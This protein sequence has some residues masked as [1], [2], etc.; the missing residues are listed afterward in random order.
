MSRP[1]P[2]RLRVRHL[3]KG[4]GPGGAERLVVA[5]VTAGGPVHHDVTFLVPEKQH[6]VPLLDAAGVAHRCLDA[7][8]AA[9]PGWIASLRS[10]LTGDPVD[11]LHVHSPALAAVARVLVRTIPSSRRPKVV[12]TEHNR[13]PRH[14]RL[15]RF[16]NRATIRFQDATI[17]VSD[18]VKATIQGIDPSRVE[19]IVHGIDLDATRESADR[20]SVRRELGFD[21]TD[22]VVVCVANL[23]KEKSLDVLVDAAAIALEREPRLRYVLVGQGPLARDVD[24]WI[25]HAGIGDRFTALGY[26]DDATRVLS[27]GDLFTLSSAHEGL[28]VAVMEA[29]ALGL[30]VVATAAG[31]VPAAVGGA[32]IVAAV[33]DAAALAAGHLALATDAA[34]RAELARRATVESERFALRRS[35]AEIEAV[36]AGAMAGE[37]VR[38]SSHS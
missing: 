26:R 38:A 28:P 9:R 31:G 15:T 34:R 1:D 18:D 35:I 19:V 21:A 16:A 2:T 3:L 13:W 14:H 30:P 20:E 17:A 6:L 32:G 4:L 12:S 8:T 27:G 10:Q 24:D 33:G 29:L 37:T 23:R 7:P 11:V 22:V 5:Q 25:L 36:Y